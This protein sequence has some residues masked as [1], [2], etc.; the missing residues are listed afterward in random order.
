VE[1][2]STRA[3]IEEVF[4]ILKQECH[5]DRCQLR[6]Y[7]DYGRYYVM[8]CFCFI[9][10]EYMRIKGLGNT[11]YRI[12]RDLLLGHVYPPIDEIERLLA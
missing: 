10:L 12:R 4:R 11:I 7:E 9:A 2:Y 8:G 5:W 6:S 1:K 3:I